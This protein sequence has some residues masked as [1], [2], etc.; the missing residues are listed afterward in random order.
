MPS[1]SKNVL[2]RVIFIGVLT[3]LWHAGIVARYQNELDDTIPLSLLSADADCLSDLG[4]T[5]VIEVTH[6][7]LVSYID[8]Q[9]ILAILMLACNKNT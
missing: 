6:G 4:G 3:T 7:P 9:E 2:D 1:R 8:H 5:V